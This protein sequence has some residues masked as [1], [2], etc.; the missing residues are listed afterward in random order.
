M[1]VI[2]LTVSHFLKSYFNPRKSR[3]KITTVIIFITVAPGDRIWQLIHPNL[4]LKVYLHVKFSV[5]LC[6]AFLK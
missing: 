6:N 1:A 5:R 2:F 3:V 4:A